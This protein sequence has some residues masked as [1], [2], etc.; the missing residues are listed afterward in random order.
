MVPSTAAASRLYYPTFK[1]YLEDTV[2]HPSEQRPKLETNTDDLKPF[3]KYRNPQ[4]DKIQLAL[5]SRGR[6][7]RK[8][9]HWRTSEPRTR[10]LSCR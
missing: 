2:A 8:G 3:V 1:P 9:N 4:K 7:G 5:E 6:S 10:P